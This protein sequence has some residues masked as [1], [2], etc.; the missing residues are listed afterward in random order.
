MPYITRVSPEEIEMFHAEQL[1]QAAPSPTTD[2]VQTSLGHALSTA[3]GTLVGDGNYKIVTRG[4]IGDRP[5]VCASPKPGCKV[6][7]LT[8]SREADLLDRLFSSDGSTEG[9]IPYYGSV[10]TFSPTGDAQ[11]TLAFEYFNGGD[12]KAAILAQNLKPTEIRL[13][14][15]KIAIALKSLH[16]QGIVHFDLNIENV[17]LR[18][19]QAGRVIDAAL[20]DF[21]LSF[22]T[23][24]RE[25]MVGISNNAILPQ[26]TLIHLDKVGAKAN[27]LLASKKRNK[28]RTLRYSKSPNKLALVE[29][30]LKAIRGKLRKLHR[31]GFDRQMLM[32]SDMYSFGLLCNQ[33]MP[34]S[35]VRQG[36]T[37]KLLSTSYRDRF[38]A[39]QALSAFASL[40][41]AAFAPPEEPTVIHSSYGFVFSK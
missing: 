2:L 22:D 41:P 13:I 38:N 29:A 12:L 24:S 26:E 25:C 19:D 10:Q 28:A 20:G 6:A 8:V 30:R 18:R 14:L 4:T 21:G 23:R 31:T 15:H 11:P 35:A 27:A 33:L 32:S 36:F 7:A 3:P 40:P 5:V 9:L 16:D 1:L 39:D 17:L 34:F 37:E